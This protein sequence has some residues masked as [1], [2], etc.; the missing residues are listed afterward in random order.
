MIPYRVFDSVAENGSQAFPSDQL[1]Q[2]RE[3]SIQWSGRFDLSNPELRK[4]ARHRGQFGSEHCRVAV[5][6]WVLSK[7]ETLTEQKASNEVGCPHGRHLG[8][9][10]RARSCC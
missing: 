8:S 10:I 6:V 2:G 9:S 4:I 3:L 7:V 1:V 5:A